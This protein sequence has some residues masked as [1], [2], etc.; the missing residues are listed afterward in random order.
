MLNEFCFI[1]EKGESAKVSFS[2]IKDELYGIEST[3][4]IENR[5][6]ETVRAKN[7]FFTKAEAENTISML[8]KN[9]VT[10]CTLCDII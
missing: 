9:Q 4:H 6:L 8:C 1:T 7:R 10:P 5:D 3:I 2:I